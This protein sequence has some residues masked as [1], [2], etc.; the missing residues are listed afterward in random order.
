MRQTNVART[1]TRSTLFGG[2]NDL[3]LQ[4]PYTARRIKP[5]HCS[6]LSVSLFAWLRGPRQTL[7]VDSLGTPPAGSVLL[8]SADSEARLCGGQIFQGFWVLLRQAAARS[9]SCVV[10]SRSN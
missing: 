3:P 9:S 4:Q 1:T 6:I 7:T 2:R 10:L 5:L 8:C